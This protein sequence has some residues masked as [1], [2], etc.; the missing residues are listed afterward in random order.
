MIKEII[1][2]YAINNN[3][4]VVS[5][6]CVITNYVILVKMNDIFEGTYDKNNVL[7][8]LLLMLLKMPLY[9]CIMTKIKDINVTVL[10]HQ[11]PNLDRG[12]NHCMTKPFRGQV[13]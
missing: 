6:H 3:I 9:T 7:S 13:C 8:L 1:C 5:I 10:L 11:R 2:C 12:A 4:C